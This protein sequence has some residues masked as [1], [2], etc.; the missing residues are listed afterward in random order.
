M[1]AAGRD[2]RLLTALGAFLLGAGLA[3]HLLLVETLPPTVTFIP[4]ATLMAGAG[5]VLLASALDPH[6]RATPPAA[7]A[8]LLGGTLVLG[9]PLLGTAARSTSM[10]LELAAAVAAGLALRELVLRHGLRAPLLRAL[11]AVGSFLVLLGAAQSL[12]QKAEVAEL[13]RHLSRYS[14]EM[15]QAFAQSRRASASF[16]NPNVFAGFLLLLLPLA[17]AGR[18]SR[19][20][21]QRGL[22]VLLLVGLALTGSGGALL[23][24]LLGCGVLLILAPPPASRL[25][26]WAGAALGVGLLAVLLVA[27]CLLAGWRPAPA[28]GK[29]TTFA[30]RLQLQEAGLGLLE[31]WKHGPPGLD[32]AGDWL[33]AEVQPG[34]AWSRYLHDSWLQLLLETGPL[35]LLGLVLLAAGMLR[36]LRRPAADP[37]GPA[38]SRG[39]AFLTGT[40]CGC[41]LAGGLSPGSLSLLPAGWEGPFATALSPVLC[42]AVVAAGLRLLRRWNPGAGGLRQALAVGTSAFVLHNL[43]DFDL[44]V[45]GTAAAFAALLAA[46]P[47]PQRHSRIWRP[48]ALGCGLLLLLM[49]LAGGLL[50]HQ[51]NQA[52]LLAEATEQPDAPALSGAGLE[53]ARDLLLE[54]PVHHLDVLEAWLQGRTAGDTTP[55]ELRRALDPLPAVLLHRPTVR[56]ALARAATALGRVRRR[57]V[58]QALSTIDAQRRPGDGLDP[59]LLLLRFTVL[60]RWDLPA[61]REAAAT[62]LDAAT[63]AGLDPGSDPRLE[64]ARRRL[65]LSRPR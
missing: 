3:A 29:L 10:G 12:Y 30:V 56:L 24:L 32:S 2:P 41:L 40:A 1:N 61:A 6:P 62:A 53:V 54:P 5:L 51:R 19:T 4:V 65:D 49:P 39:G 9:W 27:A 28:G 45:A 55:R 37:P 17:L 64:R 15:A 33:L 18:G 13:A 50:A 34:A 14:G 20:P 59:E 58:E 42:L 63:A 8:V 31:A 60:E 52:R 21:V 25:R 44:Y 57:L 23:A 35:A 36:I 46:A 11:L 48:A 47:T 43:I 22:A 38:P 26:R 7:P 16:V